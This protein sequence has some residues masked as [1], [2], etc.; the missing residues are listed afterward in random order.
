MMPLFHALATHFAASCDANQSFLGLWPWYHYLPLQNSGGVCQ[1]NL[2]PDSQHVLGGGSFIVLI[3]LAVVDDLL[4]I[5]G[6]L[7]VIYIIYAGI[8]YTMS[9]GSP[10]EVAKS[11]STIL[12]ALAGLAIALISIRFVSFLAGQFS[13]GTGST[14][15]SGLDLRSLPNPSGIA[16]G[17][18]VP[19]ILSIIFTVAGAIAFLYLVIGGFHYVSSQGDPQK[20]AKAKG[21]I[22][23]ALVG[24]I[25]AIMAQ[26]I[27]GVVVSKI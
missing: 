13:G 10:D 23:Y 1:V 3:L 14:A 25:V 12:N 6:L 21:A 27:V 18:I 19:T 20:V 11:Q 7:S 17:G 5:V 2:V 22:M 8:R 9:Q 16:N 4:R 24:L 26:T 15:T